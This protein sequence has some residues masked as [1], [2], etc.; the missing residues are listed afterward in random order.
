MGIAS[1][2]PCQADMRLINPLPDD[3]TIN[4]VNNPLALVFIL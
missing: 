2:L 1:S 3:I 4:K